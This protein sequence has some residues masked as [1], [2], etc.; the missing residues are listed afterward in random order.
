MKIIVSGIQS[1]NSLTLG[2]Y[3]GAL[4]N[5]VDMQ[6][7]E[8]RLFVFIADLHSITVNF[9]PETLKENRRS[10]ACLYKA[11]GLD[12]KKNYVFYQ[13]SVIEH[14]HLSYLLICHTYL[15]ELNRMTQFK[16]KSQKM[17]LSNQ[18]QNIPAG[19]L[20]YPT[21]MAADILL[22]DA[23][24]VPVGKDQKQH[25]ELTR[26]IAIRF[27]KKYKE[28]FFKVPNFFTKENGNKIMDLQN[29]EMKMSKSNENTKGTIFLLEPLDSIRKKIMAA[30]T[31]SLNKVNYDW[32]NQPGVTNLLT[33]YSALT[34]N[35]IELIL[36][37]Y[38]GKNYA[39]FKKDLADIVCSKLEVI[40]NNYNKIV[41]DKEID[42]ELKVNGNK[43]KEIANKKIKQIHKLLGLDSE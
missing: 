24:I 37:K 26:D 34:D 22:Y 18:T 8:N 17:T 3:L 31:D 19:L 23:D 43:C 35:S 15:G 29:P 9:S 13:S 28:G 5:F 39:E 27:N 11:C 41:N 14:S 2:N 16:D 1:T 12:F 25:L 7:N 6:S 33:I 20:Y 42:N 40:Q 32:D 30:K 38:E 21:L 36:K 4:K 10:T